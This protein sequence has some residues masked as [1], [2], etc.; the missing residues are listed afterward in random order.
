MFF[1]MDIRGA[2]GRLLDND[3]INAAL[4]AGGDDMMNGIMSRC[5]DYDR[6]FR[7]NKLRLNADQRAIAA[8]YIFSKEVKSPLYSKLKSAVRNYARGN[9]I[10][11]PFETVDKHQTWVDGRMT[12]TH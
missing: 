6:D 2:V 5:V 1:R 11:P 10:E 12:W 9:A 3:E 7:L 8:L 4:H